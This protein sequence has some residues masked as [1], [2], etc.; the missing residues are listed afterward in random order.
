MLRFLARRLAEL[1]LNVRPIWARPHAVLYVLAVRFLGILGFGTHD[2]VT[3]IIVDALT[4]LSTWIAASWDTFVEWCVGGC[5]HGV[6]KAFLDERVSFDVRDVPPYSWR[7]SDAWVRHSRIGLP[8]EFQLRDSRIVD[9]WVTCAHDC[10]TD[11][12]PL[13]V[14]EK[15]EGLSLSSSHPLWL[16]TLVWRRGIVLEV[17]ADSG[18]PHWV[19]TMV[20]HHCTA[21]GLCEWR[22]EAEE[23]GDQKKKHSDMS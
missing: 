19:V 6:L 17:P 10:E 21:N 11:S 8:V 12:G 22:K 4:G 18:T 16:L 15:D 7:S 14:E 5:I 23:V 3:G 2:I 20:D 1:E 9:V 13:G